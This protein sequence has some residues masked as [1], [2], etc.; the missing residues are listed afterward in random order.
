MMNYNEIRDKAYASAK[1]HGYHDQEYG[2]AHWAMM[3]TTELCEAI[4]ADRSGRYC[5]VNREQFEKLLE[6]KQ[7]SSNNTNAQF[8]CCFV[9]NVKD[10]VGDELADAVLRIC[11]FAG[12]RGW[13][14]DC[15]EIDKEAITEHEIMTESIV[16]I[17]LALFVPIGASGAWRLQ[18]CLA[19]IEKIADQYGIDLAW[20][21]ELKMRFNEL[22]ERLHG[23]KY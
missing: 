4:D 17:V 3:I 19:N 15:Y 1:A 11:D 6:Q 22:R 16:P 23:C 14:L 18:W 12:L 2:N 21:I 8:Y 10:T 20:H 9:E 7:Y 5:K 13:E